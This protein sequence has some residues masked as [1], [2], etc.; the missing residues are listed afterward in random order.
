LAS[1]AGLA[2]E[3]IALQSP[4]PYIEPRPDGSAV[5]RVKAVPGASF[6]ALAG[7]LGDRLKIRVAAPAEGGKANAAIVGFL[8]RALGLKASD[9]EIV[10]GASAA[11]KRIAIRALSAEQVAERLKR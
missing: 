1:R 2:A 4:E 5:L 9:L 8:A 11:E 3:S 10:G 6:D 7:P